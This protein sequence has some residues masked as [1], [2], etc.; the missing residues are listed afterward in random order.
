MDFRGDHGAGLGIE[1]ALQLDTS[2]VGQAGPAAALEAHRAAGIDQLATQTEALG[3][4]IEVG[5]QCRDLEFLGIRRVLVGKL[6]FRG[7]QD[8]GA[9]AALRAR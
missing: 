6:D 4:R 3:V 2:P 9:P 8:A 5:D 7:D 1:V